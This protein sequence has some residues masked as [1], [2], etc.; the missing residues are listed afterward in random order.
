MKLKITKIFTFVSFALLFM[1]S[2]G[3]TASVGNQD[4]SLPQQTS[5]K[6]V[7][8]SSIPPQASSI[9][10]QTSSPANIANL[11]FEGTWAPPEK[12][13]AINTVYVTPG[14]PIPNIMVIMAG[15]KVRWISKAW[16]A[17]TIVSDLFIGDLEPL[18]GV[19]SYTF[20]KACV[21]VYQI[22][23][24]GQYDCGEV[25]VLDLGQ[26]N[27]GPWQIFTDSTIWYYE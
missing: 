16:I 25:I 11:T 10:P 20:D 2:N 17:T 3:A 19:F 27:S 8:N 6:T 26:S 22:E 14:V 21:C 1:S 9:T 7:Q 24:Y 18:G 5:P 23:P 13:Q 4:S 15:T 12:G